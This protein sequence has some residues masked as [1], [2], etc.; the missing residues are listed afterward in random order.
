MRGNL[1]IWVTVAALVPLFGQSQPSTLPSLVTVA[2]AGDGRASIDLDL[3][4][5]PLSDVGSP[6]VL[7]LVLPIPAPTAQQLISPSDVRVTAISG[8]TNHSILVIASPRTVRRVRIAIKDGLKLGETPDGKAMLEFDFSY[9]FMSDLERALAASPATITDIKYRI[10]LPRKYED[11]DLSLAPGVTRIDDRAFEFSGAQSTNRRSRVWV[12]FPNLSQRALDY[13]KLAFSLLFGVLALAF[14]V[15]PLRD[16]R[17]GWF[18]FVLVLSGAIMLVAVVSSVRLTK[19]LDFLVF[20]AAALPTALWSS[21]ACVYLLL[22][23][24]RQATIA[25]QVNINGAPGHFVSVE[26]FALDPAGGALKS[27]GK[28]EALQPGGRYVFQ[29]WKR[30]QN[31]SYRVRAT[32]SGISV[33][34]SEFSVPPGK[35]REVPV[36]NVNVNLVPTSK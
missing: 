22:A 4:L 36:L 33:E 35:T 18:V 11:S 8:G 1:H 17:V 2:I 13:A 14:Q 32:H 30:A 10:V 31:K 5:P 21:F 24:R 12:S 34:S 19:G 26:L 27:V 16:R 3:N 9:P 15:Q 7:L 23:K 6:D 29:L 25:G 20:S 28:Q